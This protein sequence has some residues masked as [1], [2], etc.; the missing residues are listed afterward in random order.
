MS[1]IRRPLAL[2]VLIGLA[3]CSTR[4]VSPADVGGPVFPQPVGFTN[5]SSKAHTVEVRLA[6]APFQAE[7]VPGK[8]TNLL[9]YNGSIPGPTL[10]LA[11]GDHVVVH[12]TNNLAEPTTVHWHG[13][14]IP[15]AQ[16]GSQ[17][18]PI[19]PGASRDI[20]FDVPVGTAGTYWYHPHPNGQTA[21]QAE[22]GLAGVVRV[23]ATNDPLPPE[24]GDRLVLLSDNRLDPTGQIAETT[25]TDRMN[26]REGDTV[27]VNGV[28]LP[29]LQVRAG[30]VA[31]L[32]I[33]N[34]SAARYYQLA[35]PNQS[36]LL[37]GTDGGL[38]G[39]P[40]E[41][42]KILLAPAE[43]IEVLVRATEAPGTETF[44]QALPYDRGAMYMDATGMGTLT[45]PLTNLV[46]IR[47][48]DAAPA[49]APDV[50][51]VLRPVAPLDVA[52]AKTR[53][54]VLT[55]N[56]MVMDFWINAKKYDSTR[57]DEQVALGATEIWTVQNNGDMDH[58]FHVH[59]FR[60]QV[61]DRNGVPEP[62]VAWKDTV[63]VLKTETVRVAIRFDDFPGMWMY[64][65]HILEHE[66]LGMMGMFE[67]R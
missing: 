47:Y 49:P 63:N 6:A 45:S 64:H 3:A 60:F 13:M 32:R 61:L 46:R 24:Y 7:L 15:A 56:M 9:A 18:A 16:D 42:Q 2:L 19:A 17:L 44:L 66:E 67:V 52:M 35:I 29:T 10:E 1:R 27:F 28:V 39:A 8:K 20:I 38:I 22:H 11:E 5:L 25:D 34:A 37:V 31:R 26:G 51:A 36:L 59:G 4:N 23:R 14:H 40:V 58:P 41:R 43:R 62:F 53:P 55:E 50:P 12:F 65:C 57:V 30:E 21:S 48:S 54:F 33:V